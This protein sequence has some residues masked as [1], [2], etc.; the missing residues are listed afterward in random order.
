MKTIDLHR[1]MIR[2][3]L[4]E[5]SLMKMFDKGL[6]RGTVH[7]SIGQEAVAVGVL[8]NIKPGD[9]IFSS[10]RC[11]GHFI[12]SGGD[13]K[14][15]FYEIMGSSK[16]LCR[17]VGGSQHIYNDGFFSNGVQGSYMPIS[18]GLALGKKINNNNNIAISFIGDGT[19]GEGVVYEALNMA[20][21]FEV[22]LLIVIENNGWAQTTP[23]RLNFSGDIVKRSSGFGISSYEFDTNDVEILYKDFFKIVKDIRKNKKPILVIINTYRLGPHS[24]GDDIRDKVYLEKIKEYDPLLV[25]KEK[26][27]KYEHLVN[28]VKIEIS[29]I[30][31]EIGVEL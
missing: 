9:S 27:D 3:R 1:N 25:S 7:T 24:K 13:I 12:A 26:N 30:L 11:H 2:I 31:S 17:G 29:T 18:V 16:G 19:L 23:M 8:S 28:S 15:L 22:P 20:A 14:S 6:L 4:F 10:H 21:L 5:E